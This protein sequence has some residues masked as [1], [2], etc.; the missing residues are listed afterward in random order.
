MDNIYRYLKEDLYYD[1]VLSGICCLDNSPE[2][3]YYFIVQDEECNEINIYEIVPC[4]EWDD[5]QEY[6]EVLE[7]VDKNHFKWNA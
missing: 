3:L 4:L 7:V 2:K 1:G 5:Y 6:E